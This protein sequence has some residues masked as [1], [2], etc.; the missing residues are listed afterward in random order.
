MR[1]KEFRTK[2]S[3]SFV[4]C[5]DFCFLQLVQHDFISSDELIE[6]VTEAVIDRDDVN[7]LFIDM[8]NIDSVDIFMLS[9]FIQIVRDAILGEKQVV[10][11]HV[12]PKVYAMFRMVNLHKFF[13]I[14]Q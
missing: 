11:V 8:S 6:L 12:T 4:I 7:K 3:Y 14:I 1:T 5:D 2:S 10:F 13:D 9:A